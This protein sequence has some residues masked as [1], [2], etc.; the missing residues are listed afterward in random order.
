M[1]G[2]FGIGVEGISKP[3]NVGNLFRSAHSFGASFFFTVDPVVDIEGMLRSDTSDA[4]GHIPFYNFNSPAEIL[5]PRQTSVVAVELLEES[6]DLPS[7]RHPQRAV[8]VL[9]PEKGNV[10]PA[11]LS[12]CDHVIKIP[13]KFCVNV[14]VAGALVMYDR[15][16]S[17]GRFADRPVREGGPTDFSPE[18]LR[19]EQI[20]NRLARHKQPKA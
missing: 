14:G 16:L 3:M 2:Y 18:K 12:R 19:E 20:M 8:Y 1:R 11:M 7:F 9:G 13:M 4:F 17:L 10:S 5:L 6:V 15:L